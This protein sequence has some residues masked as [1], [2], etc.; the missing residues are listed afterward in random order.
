MTERI[1]GHVGDHFDAEAFIDEHPA[2]GGMP[3]LREHDDGS[4]KLT[5]RVVR[6]VELAWLQGRGI[7]LRREEAD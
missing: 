1:A 5:K 4:G 7:A 6:L 3:M 2:F